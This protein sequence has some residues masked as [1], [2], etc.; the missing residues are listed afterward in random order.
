[1]S[2]SESTQELFIEQ[3]EP[4]SDD[5]DI[6]PKDEEILSLKL[7]IQRLEEKLEDCKYKIRELRAKLR[8]P[9]NDETRAQEYLSQQKQNTKDM[10]RRYNFTY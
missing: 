7:Y 4:L 8:P 2:N 6:D 10:M 9:S 1:M 5:N 3:S